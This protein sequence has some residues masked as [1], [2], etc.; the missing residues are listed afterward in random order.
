M[1]SQHDTRQARILPS[2]P[3]RDVLVTVVAAAVAG[4]IGT[5]LHRS[6]ADINVPWG[7][8]AA[9]AL[10]FFSTWLAR[11]RSGAIGV[12]FHLIVCSAVVWWLAVTMGPAGDVLVP[13]A[14]KA[15]VTF[16]SQQAG[17]IWLFGSIAVQLI[18]LFFPKRFFL[19][20]PKPVAEESISVEEAQSDEGSA[21]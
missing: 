7:L 15:F 20:V 17:Y 5:V 8:V 11:R 21:A 3:F 4:L 18:V 16:F 10:V 9:F 2:H 12:G 1:V 6:G 13:I 19:P 14:S